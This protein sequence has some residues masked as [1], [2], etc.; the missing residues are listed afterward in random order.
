MDKPKKNFNKFQKL[1]ITQVAFFGHSTIEIKI[2][3]KRKF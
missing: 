3:N 1:E 2:N